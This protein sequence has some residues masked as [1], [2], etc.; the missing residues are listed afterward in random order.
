MSVIGPHCPDLNRTYTQINRKGRVNKWRTSVQH[1]G[2][3]KHL[4]DACSKWIINFDTWCR[5]LF[6]TNCVQSTFM[7]MKGTWA[8]VHAVW[9]SQIHDLCTDFDNFHIILIIFYIIFTLLRGQIRVTTHGL[10]MRRTLIMFRDPLWCIR[11]QLTGRTCSPDQHWSPD[12]PELILETTFITN[13]LK[14]WCK[15]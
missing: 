7:C 11:A 9:V 1:W 4:L 3:K 12:T 14:W 13:Q 8:H 15:H 10:Q 2:F 6:R 5:L